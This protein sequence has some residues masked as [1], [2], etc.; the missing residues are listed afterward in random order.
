MHD[1]HIGGPPVCDCFFKI[2]AATSIT[3]GLAIVGSKY[4]GDAVIHNRLHSIMMYPAE[5]TLKSS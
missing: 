3:G 4:P 2:S 1:P 5:E